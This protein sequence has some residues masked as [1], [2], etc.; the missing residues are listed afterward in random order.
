[1]AAA[2]PASINC[3]LHQADGVFQKKPLRGMP[4]D[5]SLRQYC[6]NNR[7]RAVADQA[8]RDILDP[9]E[10][11]DDEKKLDDMTPATENMTY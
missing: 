10:C 9:T 8:R 3:S 7:L 11:T 4:T 1:M 5:G 2:G 6:A